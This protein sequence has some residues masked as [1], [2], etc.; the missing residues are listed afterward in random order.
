MNEMQTSRTVPVKRIEHLFVPPEVISRLCEG[1]SIATVDEL[2][3]LRQCQLEYNRTHAFLMSHIHNDAKKK[4]LEQQALNARRVREGEGEAVG[5][6]DSWTLED[7][8]QDFRVKRQ[9]LKA[10]LRSICAS[11]H[12]VAESVAN[13]I[14]KLAATAAAKLESEEQRSAQMWGVEHSPSK[15]LRVLQYV[16]AHPKEIIPPA[17]GTPPKALLV[18]AGIKNL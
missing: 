6:T 10:Q 1:A 16:A 7:W 3:T 12:P 13:R 4:W 15:A 14:G 9:G 8:Q 11:A 17:G 2:E 5:A 18:F